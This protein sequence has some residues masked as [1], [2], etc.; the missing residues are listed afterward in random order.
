M[1]GLRVI[2]C[3]PG[4]CLQDAGRFG[5]QRFG[6]SPAGAMDPLALAAANVLVGNATGEAA[7]EF[8]MLGGDFVVED[9]PAHLAVVG[10]TMS[11]DGTAVPSLT[12][13][14]LAEGARLRVGAARDGVYAYLAAEGGFDVEPAMG[15]RSLHRRSAI[16]PAAP[17]PGQRLPL[18]AISGNGPNVLPALVRPEEGPVRV[19]LGPQR[20]RFTDEAVE[21]FLTQPYTVSPRS[22]RMGTRLSG[23]VLAHASGYNIVSDGIVTGHVQVPGDGQPIVLMRD[24]QTTG[25]YPKIA[26]IISAD[27]PRFAQLRP[28]ATIRFRAVEREE[29]VAAL[30]AQREALAALARQVKPAAAG[31]DSERLLSLNLISGVTPG[32]M[33]PP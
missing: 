22:D 4:T 23:P 13:V 30:R 10:A 32:D 19:M 9:G 6:V 28:G 15:S 18:R 21:T 33:A 26:G 3:G 29:A 7:L 17:A 14:V 11:V 8:G 25:G 5:L 12:S 20:D 1:S 2:A 24:R 27:L 31:L 16:G